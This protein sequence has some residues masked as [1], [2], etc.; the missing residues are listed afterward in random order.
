MDFHGLNEHRSWRAFFNC[1]QYCLIVTQIDQIYLFFT[2]DLGKLDL[3]YTQKTIY[4]PIFTYQICS[5]LLMVP[6]TPLGIRARKFFCE[7]SEP[8]WN[9][10]REVL[11]PKTFL[12]ESLEQ[13][14]GPFLTSQT[15]KADWWLFGTTKT[16]Q[17]RQSPTKITDFVTFHVKVRDIFKL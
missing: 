3:R 17:F 16:S 10:R 9:E 7:A 5:C 4:F 1:F 8:N 12:T 2:G 6:H 15:K 11:M 14:V 13:L